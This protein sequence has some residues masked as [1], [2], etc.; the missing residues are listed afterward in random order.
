MCF[1]LDLVICP[2]GCVTLTWINRLGVAM[3]SN[4][5]PLD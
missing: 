2:M 1:Y 4:N 5:N 3:I